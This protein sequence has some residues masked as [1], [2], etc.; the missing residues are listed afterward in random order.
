MNNFEMLILVVNVI[1]GCI[2]SGCML[3]IAF[4]NDKKKGEE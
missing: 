1:F 3:L 4:Y 2:H